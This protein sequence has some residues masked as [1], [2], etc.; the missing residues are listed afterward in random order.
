[1]IYGLKEEAARS[2]ATYLEDI[3]I[4]YSQK[5]NLSRWDSAFLEESWTIGSGYE[6]EID[7]Y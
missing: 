7:A 1:M 6:K 3:Y 2:L 5:S 4:T